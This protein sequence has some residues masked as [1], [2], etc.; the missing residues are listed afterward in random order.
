[1]NGGFLEPFITIPGNNPCDIRN[2]IP[3]VSYTETFLSLSAIYTCIPSFRKEGIG[4]SEMVPTPPQKIND[5]RVLIQVVDIS[6]EICIG[7]FNGVVLRG[8]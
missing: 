1:M 7:C 3:G 6:R 2:A 8:A 5:L 4:S